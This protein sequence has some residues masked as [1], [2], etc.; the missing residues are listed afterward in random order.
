MFSS[1][2]IISKAL[3]SDLSKLRLAPKSV[4][5][6]T[7][8]KEPHDSTIHVQHTTSSLC[9]KYVLKIYV[10][11]RFRMCSIFAR[12]LWLHASNRSPRCE[13]CGQTDIH[14][15]VHFTRDVRSHEEYYRLGRDAVQSSRSSPIFLSNFSKLSDDMAPGRVGYVEFTSMQPCLKTLLMNV[16]IITAS[17]S[18]R[19]E[20][21]GHA[22]FVEF[23]G[24]VNV[25]A[26]HMCS[27]A[28]FSNYT[29][30]HNSLIALDSPR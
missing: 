30:S 8:L 29:A 26:L 10:L 27:Y 11:L 6:D 3:T 5:C 17:V 25:F 16:A 24:F 14:D 18:P 20:G 23:V 13:I 12:I 19:F 4:L 1:I 15:Q 21:S 2:V 9:N 22:I 7:S 28:L